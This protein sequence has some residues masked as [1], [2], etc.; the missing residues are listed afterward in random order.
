MEIEIKLNLK[1]ML[2]KDPN[3]AMDILEDELGKLFEEG[4]AF[5][6]SRVL[7]ATPVWQG[8]LSENIARGPISGSGLGIH[9]TVFSNIIYGNFIEEGF[10]IHAIPNIENLADWVK[11]K[12]GLSGS[13]LYMVSRAIARKIASYGIKGRFMFKKGFEE[14]ER[15]LPKMIERAESRIIGRWNQQ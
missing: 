10:P 13:D 5:I 7:K 12:M 4:L 15:E 9:G 2:L 6:H 11:A 14:G 3:K 1:G 8:H